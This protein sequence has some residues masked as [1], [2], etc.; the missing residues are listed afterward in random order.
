MNVTKV[1]VLH[2]LSALA[3]G[4]LLAFGQAP[5]IVGVSAESVGGAETAEAIY[6]EDSSEG[7]FHGYGN[8]V[9]A[10]YYIYCDEVRTEYLKLY[11]DAPTYGNGDTS[12]TNACG[13]ISGTNV[14]VYY[15]RHYPNLI[16]DFEPGMISYG[17]YAYFP[18]M[19]WEATKNVMSSLYNLMQIP[20][21]G[22]TTSANFR[23]GLASFM[24]GRG[25][26]TTY[27]SF[28]GTETMPNLTTLGAAI[29]AGK[30]G[31]VMCSAYNFITSMNYGDGSV[32]VVK[33]TSTTG[34][35]MMV[36]GYKT[37]GYYSGGAKIAEKT[38]L[39]VSSGYSTAER[40]YMELNDYSDI[41]EAWIVNVS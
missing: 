11:S 24:S 10:N 23:S 25:Y 15:D 1:T 17:S 20:T 33:Q 28:Q 22:G 7:L 35:I 5:V 8:M 12:M 36:Y 41:D 3:I 34:H 38:F 30:V 2:K 13:A 29:D 6:Y 19:R 16:P 37:M 32:Y 4:A 31:V 14:V 39:L 40:G 18:D 26:S 21:V 27:S 9:S